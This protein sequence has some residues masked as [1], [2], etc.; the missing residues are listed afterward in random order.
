M[1]IKIRPDT[2]SFHLP[3]KQKYKSLTTYSNDKY[4]GKLIL[5]HIVD[6]NAKW[7]NPVRV[8]CQ[9]LAKLH[10]F[11]L[12]PSNPTSR[13]LSYRYIIKIQKDT[14]TK[15]FIAVQLI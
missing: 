10:V 4:A 8:I 9:Y 7:Y 1:L 14:C 12:W 15:I 3:D 13:N 11:T 2:T 6:G 5:W